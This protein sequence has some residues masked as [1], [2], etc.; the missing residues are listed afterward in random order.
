[1]PKNETK[2][3]TGSATETLSSKLEFLQQKANEQYYNYARSWDLYERYYYGDQWDVEK[4]RGT[5]VGFY[6]GEKVWLINKFKNTNYHKKLPKRTINNIF[7]IVQTQVS[8]YSETSP[9]IR[10]TPNSLEDEQLNE[11]ARKLNLFYEQIFNQKARFEMEKMRRDT[12]LFGHGFL[13]IQFNDEAGNI[14]F[15]ITK[16]N[17]KKIIADPEASEWDEVRW[18]IR[19][20]KKYVYEI[21]KEFK[22]ETTTYDDLSVLDLIEYWVRQDILYDDGDM[23]K[24]ERIVMVKDGE[25]L[26]RVGREESGDADEEPTDYSYPV[27][28]IQL[29]RAYITQG[30]WWGMS[31]VQL[32]IEPQDM[33]NKRAS[34]ED[35][36]MSLKAFP[37]VEVDQNSMIDSQQFGDDSLVIYPGQ[38]YP[39]RNGFNGNAITPIETQNVDVTSYYASIEQAKLTMQSLSGVQDT[40]QGRNV[41]GVYHAS[42]WGEI[43]DA[44]LV[45]IKSKEKVLKYYLEELA[46]KILHWAKAHLEDGGEYEVYDPKQGKLI[47]LTAEDFEIQKLM[48]YVDTIDANHYN[49]SQRMKALQEMKQYAPEIDYKE[50]VLTSDTIMPGLYNRDYIEHLKGMVGLQQDLERKQLELQI[51]QTEGEI[52]RLKNPQPEQSQTGQSQTEQSQTGQPQAEQSQ[53]GQPAQ[54]NP[55]PAGQPDDYQLSSEYTNRFVS[56]LIQNG[57]SEQLAKLTVQTVIGDIA[58][59]DP[60]LSDQELFD[61]L[62]EAFRDEDYMREVLQRIQ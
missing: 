29:F 55:Q 50:I 4:T 62:T 27:C 40:M 7:P 38:V 16:E 58:E 51:M 19:E 57:W 5:Q 59:S 2:S 17:T 21:K 60:E 42:H 18:V 48:M 25:I 23:N 36:T 15:S 53:T 11:Q 46:W 33:I 32:L 34:Q 31:D 56:A 20:F 1:M 54:S 61:R 6:N 3:H 8:V 24:W 45:R 49:V 14:P 10:W 37:P 47:T 9:S 12:A 28:P 44:A 52:E 26:H 43:N 41:K 30:G 35:F 13:M 22:V 39:K